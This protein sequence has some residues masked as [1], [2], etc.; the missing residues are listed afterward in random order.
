MNLLE[1]HLKKYH[2]LT[3]PSQLVREESDGRHLKSF[4]WNESLTIKTG[5]NQEKLDVPQ[6]DQK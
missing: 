3:F 1:F 2:I 6:K 5:S 4:L